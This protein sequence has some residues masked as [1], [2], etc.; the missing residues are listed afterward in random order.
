MS[1]QM[2]Q[3]GKGL[4][5]R[6][7]SVIMLVASILNAAMLL[8]ASGRAFRGF[9]QME[10]M[11]DHYYS[12]QD[13]TAELMNASDYLTEEVQRYTISGDRKHM[14]NYF[15][16]AEVTRRR[17]H[18]IATMEA[19]LPGSGPLTALKKGMAESVELMDREYYAMRLMAE[20]V[21]DPDIPAAL[22]E[23]VLS[24]A[25]RGLN[26]E[27]KKELA[28]RMVHDEIY[29]QQKNQIRDNMAACVA[30]L[31]DDVHGQ[32]QRMKDDTRSRM[33]V[34]CGLILL[35]T[36]GAFTILW[37]NN[38]LGINPVVRAVDH[39]QKDQKLPIMGASE[40]RYLAGT[41]N[42]MYNAYKKSI[43]SLNYK[44]SHDELTGVYN[45]AG[46]DLIRSSLDVSSTALLL[47]DADQFKEI[48]DQYGHETGDLVLK[49]IA[50]ELRNN[51]RSDDYICRIGGD[52]FVVFMVHISG[53]RQMLIEN[54][55]R[56]INADLAAK[57]DGL[58]RV[59]LSA[60]VSCDQKDVDAAEMFRQADLAL[61]Y[62]KE[63]GRHS[64][65][66]YSDTMKPKA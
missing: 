35:Q 29:Y 44:A 32:Q 8:I 34:L 59:S 3:Q 45:R 19:E 1:S 17:D 30:A 2:N 24:D 47:F 57:T 52:E 13:A 6:T 51:F 63:H 42:T 41:Y 64:C 15:T 61:Y 53:D 62:V 22:R 21:R 12:L 38:R 56:Q 9:L 36:L 39:I 23:V 55:V 5:L 50:E 11:T 65:C 27:E 33:V 28:R 10:D 14:E 48:N 18:A 31:K 54:K 25:D 43:A 46:Y 49:K 16:E 58:P 7:L 37:L 20:A 40:F 26:P 66:F 60:G 4:S